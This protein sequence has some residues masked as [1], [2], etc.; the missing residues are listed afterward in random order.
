[1]TYS[2]AGAILPNSGSVPHPKASEEFRREKGEDCVRGGHNPRAG[3]GAAPLRDFPTPSLMAHCARAIIECG[4]GVFLGEPLPGL[5][6]VGSPRAAASR[7]AV[8]LSTWL[9]AHDDGCV[10]RAVKW[11][12]MLGDWG[13]RRAR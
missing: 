9:L 2:E 12:D 4:G 6:A 13:T 7:Y 5:F 8:V 3:S 11:L 1:M 10:R